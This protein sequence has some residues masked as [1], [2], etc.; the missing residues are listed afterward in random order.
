MYRTMLS[1]HSISRDDLLFSFENIDGNR[2]SDLL[3]TGICCGWIDEN[4]TLTVN[5]KGKD[6]L[7]L[8]YCTASR[9]MLRDFINNAKPSWA[10]L[11]TRGRKESV[12]MLSRDVAACFH[13]AELMVDP[14]PSDIVDWWDSISIQFFSE[15]EAEQLLT[16][17]KGERLS[18][19]YETRRVGKSPNWTSIDSNLA[20]YDILS[21]Q[22]AN[23][24]HRLLIEVKSSTASYRHAFAYIS[25]NEWDTAYRSSN[26]CFHF[27]LLTEIPLISVLTP[28]DLL[29]HIPVDHGAGIWSEALIPF[30]GFSFNPYSYT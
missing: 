25:R 16:G 12:P 11:L 8:P 21:Y 4:D 13:D 6:Y 19:D 10:T 28:N 26:Y 20:G 23:N 30:A 14:P 18:V 7:H 22:S 29:E 9:L 1:R 3:D 5:P 17:R 27:W 15:K 2:V 24:D